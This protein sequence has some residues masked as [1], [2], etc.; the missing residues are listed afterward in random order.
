MRLTKENADLNLIDLERAAANLLCADELE[1]DSD[2]SVDLE[3]DFSRLSLKNP[4]IP[5]DMLVAAQAAGLSD[6]SDSDLDS[7]DLSPEES[8]DDS[9]VQT[10]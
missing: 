1:S 10:A 4:G 2:G 6:S 7:D 9:E 5:M 8:S 3:K